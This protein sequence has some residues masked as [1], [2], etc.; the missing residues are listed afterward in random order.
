M[1]RWCLLAALDAHSSRLP[2]HYRPGT[3][4]A[5]R[6]ASA[7]LA[8]ATGCVP[9][10]LELRTAA[11]LQLSIEPARWR[12]ASL[13]AGVRCFSGALRRVT[14]SALSSRLGAEMGLEQWR[15]ALRWVEPGMDRDVDLVPENAM[16]R[17]ACMGSEILLAH[18][19][20]AGDAFKARMRLRFPAADIQF[21][22]SALTTMDNT[23]RAR[24][25]AVVLSQDER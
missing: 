11:R 21:C 19:H 16:E 2:P 9:S 15:S 23:A 14:G 20:A 12:Q 24:I 3:A 7:T 10:P 22:G 17:I 6:R 8:G 25:A 4:R 18:L 13:G 5:L 1:L